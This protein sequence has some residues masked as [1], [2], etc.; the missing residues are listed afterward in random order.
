MKITCITREL[1]NA[2]QI[3]S[4]AVS[5]KPQT[6]ILS[7]IHLQA[8]NGTL[9]LQATNYELGMLVKIPAEIEENGQL[10]LN[11]RY[12]Q[13]VVRKLSGEKVTLTFQKEEK[14]VQIQS[15]AAKFTLLS[16]SASEFPTIH[17]LEGTLS[18]TMKNHVLSSFIRKTVF[19]CATDESRPVF[20]GCYLDINDKLVTMAATNT[21][22]LSV[23]TETLDE[24]IGTTKLI[25]PAKALN[26]LQHIIG[27]DEENDVRVICT[28]KQI[29][30]ECKNVYMISRLIEGNFPAFQNVIPQSFRTN[31]VMRTEELTDAVDRVSLIS[32]ANE[33]NIIRLVFSQGQ[34]HIFSNNPEVGNAEEVIP[35]T[36][37]GPDVN[38]A[39]NAQYISDV[40]K[41]MDGEECTFAMNESLQAAAIHD[42]D[43]DNF[44]YVVTPVRT[45]H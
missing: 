13:E 28:H 14:I 39:F 29:S 30:F 1:T 35:A 44:L 10:V 7:G 36:V 24:G 17:Y 5:T 41:Y 34:L 43:D 37:T 18:F 26:E 11:G 19:S 42:G 45:A 40:L 9:E 25:I 8:S 23:K 31:A 32:R 33:Y 20:T 27:S 6:P 22:R 38:I 2:I 16:M 12:L 4:K 21:H 15:N 3:V